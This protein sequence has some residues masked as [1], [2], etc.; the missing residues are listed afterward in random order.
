MQVDSF[1]IFEHSDLLV[2]CVAYRRYVALRDWLYAHMYIDICIVCAFSYT[3]ELYSRV[4][5]RMISTI[6]TT[7]VMGLARFGLNHI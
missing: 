6:Y 4:H 2:Y 3:Y 7:H 5:M 1:Y